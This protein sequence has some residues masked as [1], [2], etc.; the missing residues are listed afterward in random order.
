MTYSGG[1]GFR[2]RDFYMD[3]AYTFTKHPERIN[4]LY[5]SYDAT[6]EWYEQAKLQTN[7]GKFILTFGFRF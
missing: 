7:N 6:T 3:A 4:N 1:I 5:L 2:A